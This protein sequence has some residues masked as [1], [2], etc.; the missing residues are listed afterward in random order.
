MVLLKEDKKS[1]TSSGDPA[2]SHQGEK[3]LSEWVEDNK[4]KVIF[5][6]IGLGVI[7][8]G[9]L[10]FA[11]FGAKKST[12]SGN[13]LSEADMIYQ[14]ELEQSGVLRE[15]AQQQLT[16]LSGQITTLQ[17]K[18]DDP[19]AANQL[20]ELELKREVLFKSVSEIKSNHSESLKKYSDFFEKNKNE[21][22]GKRA[23][24]MAASLN[25]ENKNYAAADKILQELVQQSKASSFYGW[26]ARL[27]LAGVMEEEGKFDSALGTVDELIKFAPE[28]LKPIA[29][30]EKGRLNVL[31]KNSEGAKLSFDQLIKEFPE[32]EQAKTA[33]GLI[34]LL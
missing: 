26:R 25:L 11:I 6:L 5:A 23:G 27:M 13:Q 14:K 2:G 4:P 19:Q 12:M 28:E 33:K 29:L 18:K 21:M 34:Q 15:E 32:S 20:K 22:T 31:S 17:A 24:I 30:L 16:E 8:V 1:L 3:G 7:F 9:F 10:M